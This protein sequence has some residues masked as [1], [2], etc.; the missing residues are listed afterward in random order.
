MASPL[1]WSLPEISARLADRRLRVR[2]LIEEA[3]SWITHLGN[4]DRGKLRRA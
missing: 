4:V 2:A 3:Q 1:D